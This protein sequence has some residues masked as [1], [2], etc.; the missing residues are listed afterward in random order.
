MTFLVEDGTGLSNATS[1][2]SVAGVRAYHAI[3]KYSAAS[4]ALLSDGAIELLAQEATAM[5]ER[6][7]TFKGCAL[8]STQALQLPKVDLL[9]KN[10]F[11]IAGV[12]T[13]AKAAVSDLVYWITQKNREKEPTRG[14]SAVKVDVVTVTLDPNN[15]PHVLPDTV[16]ALLERYVKE[17]A[18][19][20]QAFAKARR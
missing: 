17:W 8:K 11:P 4:I 10:G 1:Y 6:E 18:S 13:E 20:G 2:E 3:K 14:V 16:K 7:A 5:I 19:G 9:S 15:E 12:P